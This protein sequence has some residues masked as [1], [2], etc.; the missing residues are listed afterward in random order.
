MRVMSGFNGQCQK[1]GK[2]WNEG[3]YIYKGI[4]QEGRIRLCVDRNCIIPEG[5]KLKK[6]KGRIESR[7]ATYTGNCKLC[8]IAFYEGQLAYWGKIT[9]QEALPKTAVCIDRECVEI[10]IYGKPK[11]IWKP[12]DIKDAFD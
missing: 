6:D 7:H 8:G 1:C 5:I 4:D 3:E 9:D 2:T 10:Q 11:P 12:Y